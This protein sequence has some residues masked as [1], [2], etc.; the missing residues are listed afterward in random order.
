MGAGPFTGRISAMRG[1]ITAVLGITGLQE[2]TARS[3]SRRTL[4]GFIHALT[5]VFAEVKRVLE[6]GWR[7]VAKH[8]GW[9]HQRQPR[10]EGAR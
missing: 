4:A 8:W 9:L 5:A 2:S 10:M 3:A 1:Y 7:C 6:I